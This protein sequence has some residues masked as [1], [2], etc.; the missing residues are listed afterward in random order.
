MVVVPKDDVI[1]DVADAVDVVVVRV[2]VDAGDT[3]NAGGD[4]V[5]DIDVNL[6]VGTAVAPSVLDSSSLRV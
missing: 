2:D 4:A 6:I 1:E 5:D 3:N